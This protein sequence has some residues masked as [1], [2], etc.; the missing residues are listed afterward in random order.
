MGA[1]LFNFIDRRRQSR[2]LRSALQNI[3]SQSIERTVAVPKWRKM[4]GN[5]RPPD[6]LRGCKCSYDGKRSERLWRKCRPPPSPQ[7]EKDRAQLSSA[8]CCWRQRL[9]FSLPPSL[10]RSQPPRMTTTTAKAKGDKMPGMVKREE[11]RGEEGDL[12]FGTRSFPLPPW[13]GH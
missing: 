12:D 3:A 6:A 5:D 9:T 7:P 2:R 8:E 4:R 11:K 1:T 10:T 13:N